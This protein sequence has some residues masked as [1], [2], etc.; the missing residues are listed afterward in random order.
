MDGRVRMNVLLILLLTPVLL[1]ISVGPIS[2]ELFSWIDED[3]KVRV[4]SDSLEVPP[5]VLKELRSGRDVDRSRVGRD[6]D[7]ASR[8]FRWTD[9]EGKTHFTDKRSKVPARYRSDVRALEAGPDNVYKDGDG[10]ER[11]AP[12]TPVL[13]GGKEYEW[14]HDSQ[15]YEAALERQRRTGKP[16]LVYFHADWCKFCKKFVR[17]TLADPGVK[18]YLSNVIKVRITPDNGDEERGLMKEFGAVSYPSVYVTHPVAFYG[19]KKVFGLFSP[20]SF[21]RAMKK[22][23]GAPKAGRR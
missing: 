8:L 17:E 13:S 11:P 20:A 4:T 15:G 12:K 16:M 10:G 22:L 7:G 1:F 9:D 18:D 19:A 21:I 6:G 2:A 5:E 23:L 3:G 14:Y